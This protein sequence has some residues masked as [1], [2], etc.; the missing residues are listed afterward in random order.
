MRQTRCAWTCK[1]ASSSET[2]RATKKPRSERARA[3]SWSPIP[4]APST[5]SRS[6]C[7]VRQIRRDSAGC[8]GGAH[9]LLAQL[10]DMHRQTDAM[11]RAHDFYD[12]M[13]RLGKRR[14]PAELGYRSG[15]GIIG[16][17]RERV[18]V[19]FAAILAEQ[20]VEI[21]RGSL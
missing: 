21:V 15:A 10:G 5:L 13:L 14:N 17:E 12:V 20:T 16:R 6:C 2:R 18:P 8:D 9:G 19:G 3:A 11:P 1:S 4:T 7:P